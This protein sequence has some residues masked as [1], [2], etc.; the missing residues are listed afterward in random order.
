M[1]DRMKLR[2]LLIVSMVFLSGCLDEGGDSASSDAVLFD[3]ASS[4]ITMNVYHGENLNN[5]TANYTITITLNHTAAP[6]HADNMRKHALKGNY[7]NTRFHRVIDDFMIQGGD[8]EKHDG[9]GGYAADWY[10]FCN[11][12]NDVAKDDCPQSDWTVPDEADNGLLHVPCVISM[13]KT[14]KPNTAGSQFFIVPEDSTPSHLDGVHTVFGT[15]TEGCEH[16]T[17]ISEVETD[18]Y[19]RPIVPVVIHTAIASE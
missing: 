16:I 9:T 14:N 15:V 4:T 11:G 3:G 17:S 8:F 6:M 12:Q 5:A 1:D 10:G 18:L 19:D 2:A 13:A 7:D